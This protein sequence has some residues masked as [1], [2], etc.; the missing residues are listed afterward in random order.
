MLSADI[1]KGRVF[2]LCV[3]LPGCKT[4]DNSISEDEALPPYTEF[5]T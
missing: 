1:G 5:L 2:T 3:L 4:G